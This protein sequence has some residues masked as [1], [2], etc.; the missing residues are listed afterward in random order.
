[1]DEK[2]S[3]T[4]GC[5]YFPYFC[6]DHDLYPPCDIAFWQCENN[7]SDVFASLFHSKPSLLGQSHA[8]TENALVLE[9][10]KKFFDRDDS[11]DHGNCLRL[12][13]GRLCFCPITVSR[14]K[15][16]LQSIYGWSDVSN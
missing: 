11:Y 8:N 5:L 6:F 9:H 14:K 10:V 15:F 12:F 3:S 1:M 2:D 7:G 4:I 16:F 13:I